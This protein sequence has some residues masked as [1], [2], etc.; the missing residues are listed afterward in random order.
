M[1]NDKALYLEINH[2]RRCITLQGVKESDDLRVR[3]TWSVVYGDQHIAYT[4]AAL[5]SHASLCQAGD[6]TAQCASRRACNPKGAPT[7]HA[8]TFAI[9]C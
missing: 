5:V 2:V 9:L 6:D 1:W 3:A 7:D 4:Q 8:Q